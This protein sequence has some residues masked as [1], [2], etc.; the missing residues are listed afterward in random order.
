M[1]LAP[2]PPLL[3][4]LRGVG[5]A[6]GEAFEERPREGEDGGGGDV[7]GRGRDVGAGVDGDEEARV[8]PRLRGVADPTPP[9][10]GSLTGV[11]SL[12]GEACSFD[13][14]FFV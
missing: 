3:R 9:V 7:G 6:A 1:S 5:A 14:S 8:R 11:F 13:C 2:P 12:H 4:V 10:K